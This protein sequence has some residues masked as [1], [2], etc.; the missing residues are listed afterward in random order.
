MI[1]FVIV[2]ETMFHTVAQADPKL[3]EILLSASRKL[4]LQACTTIP[5]L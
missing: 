2:F 4:K 1:I 3:L 5:Q